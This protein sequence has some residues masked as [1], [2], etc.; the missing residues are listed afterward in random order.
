LFA[1][2]CD[3]VT[4]SIMAFS[5]EKF[6]YISVQLQP[7]HDAGRDHVMTGGNL[8]RT[9]RLFCSDDN[10][11]ERTK[12]IDNFDA[13]RMTLVRAPES[14][15]VCW[16]PTVE[17]V[18]AIRSEPSSEQ[19]SG[20]LTPSLTSGSPSRYGS[21]SVLCKCVYVCVGVYSVPTERVCKFL[22][23][24]ERVL[25]VLPYLVLLLSQWQPLTSVVKPSSWSPAIPTRSQPR[26]SA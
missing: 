9:D 19:T 14:I 24:R 13:G 18:N 5:Y 3:M 11:A 4:S 16:L 23:P 15:K 1:L 21:Y 22:H 17:C 20:P 8:L 7:R 12:L 6:A 10:N 2:Q 25:I 26:P